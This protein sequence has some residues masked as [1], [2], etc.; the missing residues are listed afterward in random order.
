MS[1]QVTYKQNRALTGQVLDGDDIGV[2]VNDGFDDVVEVGV[3]HVGVDLSKENVVSGNGIIRRK[4]H[5]LQGSHYT[6]YI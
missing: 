3:A 2:H 4:H 1:R 6:K 5:F